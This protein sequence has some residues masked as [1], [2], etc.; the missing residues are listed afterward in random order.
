MRK[1]GT[2][3][4]KGGRVRGGKGKKKT[5]LDWLKIPMPTISKTRGTEK[6]GKKIHPS[7]FFPTNYPLISRRDRR[8]QGGEEGGK[9]KEEGKELGIESQSFSSSSCSYS[10]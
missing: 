9:K 6:K 1:G 5:R 4:G 8:P 3:E 10:T 2:K 7:P